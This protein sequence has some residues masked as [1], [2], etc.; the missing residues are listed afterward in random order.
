MFSMSS[1]GD[2]MSAASRMLDIVATISDGHDVDA[3]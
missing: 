1:I 3:P 2:T